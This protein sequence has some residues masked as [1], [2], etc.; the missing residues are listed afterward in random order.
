MRF[1][2]VLLTVSIVFSLITGCGSGNAKGPQTLPV[3]GKVIF[4]KGGDVKTLYGRQ[5]RVEFESVDH[6]G[7]RAAG[8]IEEDGSC[9]VA[10]AVEG[11]GSQGAVPGTHR[12]R[13]LLDERDEKFVAPQFVDFARSG[14]TVKLPSNEPIEIRVW[15]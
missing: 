2:G 8:M 5:A 6:P 4:T 7:M 1:L 13:L 10:T 15:R 3:R 12:V 9:T 14:I 11:G